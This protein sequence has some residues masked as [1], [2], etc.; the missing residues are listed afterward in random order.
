LSQN[1]PV[2]DSKDTTHKRIQNKH[3]S[4]RLNNETR[5][6]AC[7]TIQT[8][9]RRRGLTRRSKVHTYTIGQFLQWLQQSQLFNQPFPTAQHQKAC[10][11]QRHMRKRLTAVV[12][13]ARQI[14][15]CN[16]RPIHLRSCLEY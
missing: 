11:R 4:A 13:T 12:T 14:I 5:I 2:G 16:G 15:E 7:V 1:I 9:G 6:Q 8:G 10:I 3:Y